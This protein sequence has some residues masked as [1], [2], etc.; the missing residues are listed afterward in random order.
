MNKKSSLNFK[1]ISFWFAMIAIT[2]V[3]I[4]LFINNL[5]QVRVFNSISD[6]E[7]A[8]LLL[9]DDEITKQEGTYYV[10][11][12][13]EKSELNVIKKQELEP[14]ILNYF[15]YV[16]LENGDTPIYGY[17]IDEFGL[18]YQYGSVYKY[19]GTLHSDIKANNVPMLVKVKNGSISNVYTTE[20]K[21]QSE[22]QTAMS[23]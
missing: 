3:F 9:V 18:G 12:Y 7:R 23:K 5:I 4:G 8:G 10:Y 11:I 16:S 14:S 19:L 13:S 6:I 2:A 20:N 1:V 22:L 15:T 21:I 17:C